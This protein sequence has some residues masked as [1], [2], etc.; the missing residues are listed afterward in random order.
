MDKVSELLAAQ[1]SGAEVV[2]INRLGKR[3]HRFSVVD[4]DGANGIVRL[5]S[6]GATT[7]Q[8]IAD[9]SIA[10]VGPRE[11]VWEKPVK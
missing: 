10:P 11:I 6:G 8:R 5:A 9:V 2:R 7:L 3:G 1:A 4:V